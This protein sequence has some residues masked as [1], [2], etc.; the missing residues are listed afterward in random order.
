MA[1]V[2]VRPAVGED[3]QPIAQIWLDGWRVGYRGLVPDRVLDSLNLDD[4]EER[5]RRRLTDGDPGAWTLVAV[6]EQDVVGYCRLALP[7]RDDDAGRQTGEIASIYVAADRRR[8]GIGR[9]LLSAALAQFRADGS[10]AVTLW[11]FKD[12]ASAREF[13]RGHG[14]EPDGRSAY[15]ELCELDDVRLR[16]EL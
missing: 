9:E 15:D 7:S 4:R 8:A 13:Y 1:A 14:F 5:W 12:N 6:V 11:V 10:T 16:L 2:T 3:A